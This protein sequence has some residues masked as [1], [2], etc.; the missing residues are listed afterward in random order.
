[1]SLVSE[2]SHSPMSEATLGSIASS[3]TPYLS[4][5]SPTASPTLSGDTEEGDERDEDTFLGDAGRSSCER[6][7]GA[8]KA[9]DRV[10]ARSGAT[11]IEQHSELLSFIA[12]KERKCL[13]L[14]EGVWGYF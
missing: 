9:L 3:P 11:L 8:L 14:R 2:R 13:D 7:T 6:T 1:M 12:K 4:R 5:G 10:A